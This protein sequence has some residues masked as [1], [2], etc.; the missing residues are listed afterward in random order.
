M[1]RPIDPQSGWVATPTVFMRDQIR[2]ALA[3]VDTDEPV[4]VRDLM[5]MTGISQARRP[6]VQNYVRKLERI[7]LAERYERDSMPGRVFYG[8]STDL[9]D[10]FQIRLPP[11]RV[12]EP[13]RTRK[14]GP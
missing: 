12:R 5:D 1:T 11:M 7:G 14:S 2:A 13:K 3:S 10:Q 8:P 4:S 9:L 6:D